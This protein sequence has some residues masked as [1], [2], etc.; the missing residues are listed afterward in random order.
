MRAF[1][2]KGETILELE[3]ELKACIAGGYRPS[4]A[5][6]FISPQQDM[7]A[8]TALFDN[9][10]IVVFGSTSSGEFT[11]HGSTNGAIAVLLLDIDHAYFAVIF[12]EYE[13]ESEHESAREAGK[14]ALT[15]FANPAL[16]VCASHV[17]ASGESLIE[18]FVEAV[19]EEATVIG[20]IAGADVHYEGSSV[21]TNGKTSL[22]GLIALVIDEDHVELKGVAVSGWKP[23]GYERTITKT[24]GSWILEVDNKPAL[25]IYLKYTGAKLDEDDEGEG[26]LFRN[27]GS[28]HPLQVKQKVG[29]PVMRPPYML[30]RA[31]KSILCGG[32]LQEGDKFRFS[33]PPDFNI[34]EEVVGSAQE[35]KATSMAEAEALLI[36][37][38]LARLISLGPMAVK[39]L[40]GITD[41]WNIPMAGFFTLGEFGKVTDGRSNFHGTTC[42]WV[43]IREK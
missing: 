30:N 34:V 41:V 9:E 3:S 10:D 21:F 27:L 31:D 1:S 14:E 42:S 36:F 29:Y 39:E 17:K 13:L 19:G 4:L 20:G 16:I 35:I 5:F 15:T 18:G 22:N 37:S 32:C 25:D 38:C 28:F 24:E 33:M 43:A 6:V 11:D 7:Q 2:I 12:K 40:E 26:D 23:L 8:V